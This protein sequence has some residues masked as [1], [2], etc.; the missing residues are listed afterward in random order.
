MAATLRFDPSLYFVTD[1]HL[2]AA[3]GVVATAAEAVAGGATAVQLRDPMAPI[4]DLF[5]AAVALVEELEGSAVPVIVNDRVDVALGAGAAGVHLGQSDLP[6]LDARRIAGPGLLVGLSVTTPA[7]AAA[8]DDLPAG[9]VD[10][11]G[12]GPIFAT[13]T[14]ADAAPPIGIE[15]LRQACAATGLPCVA[16]G[17]VGPD[18]ATDIAAA[19]AAGVAVVSAIAASAD[20]RRAAAELRHRFAAGRGGC[21]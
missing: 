21:R 9:T 12:V 7:E 3:R 10:Y 18:A 11:L 6:A 13:P 14:K 17:G 4:R 16:I 15:G 2:C 8:A 5:A 19:G 20:P 1:P